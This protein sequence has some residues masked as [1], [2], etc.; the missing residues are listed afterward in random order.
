MTTQEMPV[1]TLRG[2][3]GHFR[4]K[5]AGKTDY[6]GELENLPRPATMPSASEAFEAMYEDGCV[7]FPNVLSK[8]EVAQLRAKF[9][10]MGEPDEKYDMPKWCFNKHLGL[11]YQNDPSLLD[12]IDK[13]GVID[14]V[15][16][17]HNVP[18]GGDGVNNRN[19]PAIVIGGTI[20]I[21]GKG[22]KMGV[23]LD[24]LPVSVPEYV[25]NDPNVRIPIFQSTVHYYLNDMRADLGPT[26]VIPGSHKAGRPPVDETSWN[27]VTPKAVMVNAGDAMLFRSDIW[28]G[29]ALNSSEERRYMV[30]V[31]YGSDFM[32]RGFPAMKYDAYWSKEVIEKA[33]PRQRRLLGGAARQPSASPY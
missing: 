19:R 4:S 13:P 20:W 27:G 3:N 16:S 32:S 5:C 24:V 14:V 28:H 23:H 29:A 7:I 6:N 21:T 10:A 22:R 31:F 25:H 11:D 26:T 30:Q 2:W 1:D 12:L 18:F 8:D 17:I 33:S 9:D 15:D